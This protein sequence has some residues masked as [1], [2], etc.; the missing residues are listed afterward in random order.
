MKTILVTLTTM[1]IGLNSALAAPRCL[2]LTKHQADKAVRLA[3]IA[4]HKGSSMLFVSKKESGLVK[5]LGIWSEQVA[6]KSSRKK[7]NAAAY[8][9]FVDGRQVDL[10]LVYL[11]KDPQQSKASNL[12][13]L[14]GCRQARDKAA[15]IDNQVIVA[16]PEENEEQE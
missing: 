4:L 16:A 9:V 5:P 1:L 2:D 12:G 11:A 13:R 7:P 14:V 6:V 10:A 8:R 15:K 3:K